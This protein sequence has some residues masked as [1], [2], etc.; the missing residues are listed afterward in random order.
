VIIPVTPD[1]YE[2]ILAELE[3]LGIRLEEATRQI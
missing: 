3:G 1:I 2:P